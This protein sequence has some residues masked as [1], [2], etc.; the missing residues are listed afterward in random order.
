MAAIPL[1]IVP[2]GLTT[3]VREIGRFW[4]L[5]AILGN[6]GSSARIRAGEPRTGLHLRVR[7]S[8]GR[9]S[10]Q[11]ARWQIRSVYGLRG[12]VLAEQLR[13]VPVVTGRSIRT[14]DEKSTPPPPRAIR[15]RR[16]APMVV[17]W[18]AVVPHARP[19]YVDDAH[20]AVRVG[21]STSCRVSA[22][23]GMIHDSSYRGS[24]RRSVPRP[25]LNAGTR[26]GSVGA[27]Q[28]SRRSTG[29]SGHPAIGAPQGSHGARQR[30]LDSGDS[31]LGIRNERQRNQRYPDRTNS[32]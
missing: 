24:A 2:D 17:R 10:P 25:S 5:R 6:S 18:A 13:T 14:G 32:D 19:G 30:A 27:T 22:T 9:A 23:K 1:R 20:A 29:V 31:A 26:H 16:V 21:R 3:H 28:R 4:P 11:P 7:S 8:A 12:G 15:I